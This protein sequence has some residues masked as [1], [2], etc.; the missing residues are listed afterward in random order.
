MENTDKE[1]QTQNLEDTPLLNELVSAYKANMSPEEKLDNDIELV[2]I[3]SIKY[4]TSSIT[5]Q[6]NSIT[7]IFNAKPSYQVVCAQSGY[8][9]KVTSMVYKDIVAIMNSNLSTYE[10]K[11]ETY[12]ILYSKIAGYSAEKWAPSFEEW[13]DMTSYGD[14]E[15]LFYGLYCATFQ[16]TSSIKF[17]CPTCGKIAT[18][19]VDNSQLVSVNDRKDMLEYT[20]TIS[21]EAD[22]L[23]HIKEYSMV[24]NNKNN[25]KY[26]K[27][28]KSKIIF[29]VKIPSLK[30]V[31]ND[32]KT[33]SEEALANASEDAEQILLYTDSV[34]IPNSN[35]SYSKIETK[36]DI[37]PLINLLDIEEM[38]LLN[39]LVT[40]LVSEKKI[41]YGVKKA[42]CSECQAVIDNI[43]LDMESLLF[44]QIS[45]KRL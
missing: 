9:A 23:E 29:G 19:D 11:K 35:G 28:P 31:L 15:T 7:S 17:R 40:K 4:E 20:K 27:L 38:A 36:E 5:D 22:T 3:D 26:I 41:S 33:N 6:R 39:R 45:E 13:L 43:P 1:K 37:L 25:V 8:M 21:K 10:S 34:S 42:K 44:F 30:K 2:D 16:N 18:I 14:V 32:Y 12:K 24:I